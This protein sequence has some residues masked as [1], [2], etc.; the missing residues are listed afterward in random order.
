M[1]NRIRNRSLALRVMTADDAAGF[2]QAGDTVGVSGFRTGCAKVVPVAIAKRAKKHGFKINLLSGASIGVNVDHALAEADALFRRMPFQQDPA[3]RRAI[4]AGS[5]RFSDPHLSDLPRQLLDGD[6]GVVDVAIIEAIAINDDG[7]IVP[8]MSVGC[9]PTFVSLARKVIVEINMA[10]PLALEGIHE[11]PAYTGAK[12][13]VQQVDE[14]IG[15]SA[16]ACA[17]NKIVAIVITHEPDPGLGAPESD[18]DT[19][20]IAQHLIDLFSHE[21][22]VGHLSPNLLPLEVG[23]GAVSN[24]VLRGFA[25]SPFSNLTMYSEV[26]QDAAF[27]L[28]ECGKLR[29][30]SAS[31][32][33]LSPE[34]QAF[35][36]A[37]FDDYADKIVL[38]PQEVSNS[39]ETIRFLDLI[40]INTALEADIYGNVNSTHINGTHMLNGI[41]G[42]G[43]FARN[44]RLAIFVTKSVAKDGNISSIVPMVTHVDHTEHDVD[45]IITE[46]GAA[47]LRGLSPRERAQLVVDRCVHPKFRPQM[48]AY[49]DR[50]CLKGGHTP[51]LLGEA[52]AWHERFTET[53]SML[54]A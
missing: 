47:D 2:V 40:A 23:V 34:K 35:V 31:A 30:A 13:A 28:I 32:I 24:A 38:R 5:I 50:A 20:R 44:A 6:L 14:R 16:I 4:N 21:V 53:G 10:Q 8:S 25:N 7:S 17:P 37:H 22:A 11:I 3:L 18:A 12:R 41:G 27:E 45:V 52:F 19:S 9:S 48:Q 46:Q 39:P 29:F 36:L 26:I 49:F 1:N 43:D 33:V 54:A 51:H 42:A 15:R